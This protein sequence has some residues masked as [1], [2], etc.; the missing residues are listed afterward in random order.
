MTNTHWLP[1]QSQN[2]STGPTKVENVTFGRTRVV[3]NMIW[4]VLSWSTVKLQNDVTNYLIKYDTSPKMALRTIPSNTA[5]YAL[6]LKVPTSN[7]TLTVWVVAVRNRAIRD[8]GDPSDPQSITYTSM[9]SDHYLHCYDSHTD[10]HTHP[11][12]LHYSSWSTSRFDTCQQNL[13]QHHIPVVPTWWHRKAERHRLWHTAQWNTSGQHHRDSVH[14]GRT[15]TWHS[16]HHQRE[17]QEC[18]WT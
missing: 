5:S 18:Y 15:D 7:T 11:L 12:V 17:D 4:Q 16:A 1:I 10:C 13:S 6:K 8:E 14:S 2:S 9:F 3:N